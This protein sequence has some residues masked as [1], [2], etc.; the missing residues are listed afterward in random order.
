MAPAM[1]ISPSSSLLA[2][3]FSVILLLICSAAGTKLYAQALGNDSGT[4]VENI[5]ENAETDRVT[6]NNIPQASS[7]YYGNL[8]S[9]VLIFQTSVSIACATTKVI[10][11]PADHEPPVRTIIATPIQNGTYPVI[12][13]KHGFS[14]ANCFYTQ[15][16]EYLASSG[17]IVVAPQ[18]QL[19]LDSNCTEEIN[20][21]AEVAN[22]IPKSLEALLNA[23]IP[24]GDVVIPDVSKLVMAGHSRGG[25]IA[26]ALALGK[27]NATEIPSFSALATLD[28]VDGNGPDSEFIPK[29]VQAGCNHTENALS[30][31][32]LILGTGYG[33]KHSG[34]LGIMPPCAPACCSHAGYFN[35]SSSPLI[36]HFVA[37]E[38]GHLDFL[39]DSEIWTPIMCTS[40]TSKAPMRSFSGR[41]L[42]AFLQANLEGNEEDMEYILEK[43][44][45][46]IDSVK[47]DEPQI[48]TEDTLILKG[49]LVSNPK[50]AFF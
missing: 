39:D 23:S 20:E 5:F 19:T 12:L 38:Y 30:I 47:L 21:T 18:T 1:A 13:F 48:Y 24:T 36:Y 29:M 45:E 2:A 4:P 41:L 28:P 25:K 42:V 44:D 6:L 37:L 17:Y 31:P 50:S 9:N 11:P 43:W 10:R 8:S 26:F 33:S 49:P 46:D 16:F 3:S 40:G 27:A 22:W 32:V 14:L 34:P 7:Q 35:C 15:L